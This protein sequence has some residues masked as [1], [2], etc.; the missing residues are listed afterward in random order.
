MAKSYI[1]YFALW[2]E[3]LNHLNSYLSSY[4]RQIYVES[5][6]SFASLFKIMID[7]IEGFTFQLSNLCQQICNFYGTN[8]TAFL[9]GSS[10]LQSIL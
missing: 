9:F 8:M 4:L 5:I 10:K 7:K 1:Y 3:W 6:S 2:S